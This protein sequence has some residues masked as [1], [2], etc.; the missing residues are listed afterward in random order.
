MFL[1]RMLPSDL[2]PLEAP[3]SCAPTPPW[4][5]IIQGGQVKFLEPQDL[6]NGRV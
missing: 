1:F 4:A 6:H 2:H 3:L 5:R